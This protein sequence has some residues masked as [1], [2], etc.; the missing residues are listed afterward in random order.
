MAGLQRAA[1]CRSSRQPPSNDC[2]DRDR[3]LDAL[4]RAV[5]EV[6]HLAAR[7]LD[8]VPS[9]DVPVQPVPVQH[10][11]T[12]ELDPDVPY[13][14]FPGVRFVAEQRRES[15]DRKDGRQRQPETVYLPY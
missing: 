14:S 5:P 9:L 10:A 2:L 15:A 3:P 7:L 12:D 11:L 13:V 8:A 4:P 1:K 6:L